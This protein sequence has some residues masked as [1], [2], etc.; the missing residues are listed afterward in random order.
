[1]EPISID[2]QLVSVLKLDETE[3]L[4]PNFAMLSYSTLYPTR[5]LGF[6]CVWY[7]AFPAGFFLCWVLRKMFKNCKKVKQFL[8]K[9]RDK[10]LANGL[11][12]FL[13]STYL[14]T[15]VSFFLSNSYM[16]FNTPGNTANSCFSVILGFVMLLFP[17]FVG[18]FYA[19]NF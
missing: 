9:M 12:L 10:Y 8:R 19:Y 1:M 17:I 3:P 14:C 15:C 11:I 7:I 13:N 2:Q 5:N 16:R 4:S 6:N 18:V